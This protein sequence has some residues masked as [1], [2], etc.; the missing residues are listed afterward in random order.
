MWHLVFTDGGALRCGRGAWA[1]IVVT[2]DGRFLE[3]SGV[4]DDTTNSRMELQ[5][6]VFGLES[7]PA[8]AKAAL[9][10]DAA[11]VAEGLAR[12]RVGWEARNWRRSGG[13]PVRNQ[14]LWRQLIRLAGTRTVVTRRVPGHCGV[15]LNHQCDRK[16]RRLLGCDT[17]PMIGVT[18]PLATAWVPVCQGGA[19]RETRI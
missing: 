11:Y 6:A 12:W 15:P 8:G 17:A 7:V 9:I 18:M 3:G 13:G 16:V 19:G 2:P 5:A 4:A 1:F 14:D 10:T